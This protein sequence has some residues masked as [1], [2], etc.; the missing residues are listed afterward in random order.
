MKKA[1]DEG[2][3]LVGVTHEIGFARQVAHRVVS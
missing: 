1:A 3:I 2:M